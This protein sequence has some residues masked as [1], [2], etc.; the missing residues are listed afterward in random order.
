MVRFV[1][2]GAEKR[3]QFTRRRLFAGATGLALLG[4][5]AVGGRANA[6]ENT[7][8]NG[9]ISIEQRLDGRNIS[10]G[11][12]VGKMPPESN[13]PSLLRAI[14]PYNPYSQIN[15]FSIKV[16]GK[17]IY[18]PLSAVCDIYNL[19]SAELTSVGTGNYRL[20]IKAADGAE[21]YKVT[22]AFNSELINGRTVSPISTDFI[23]EKTSYKMQ[24]IP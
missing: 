8:K 22:L 21:S 11:I 16:D 7:P 23:L 3:S 5:Y 15:S 2:Q 1:I 20:T 19:K 18:V 10:V 17:S 13:I 6:H 24:E 14:T 9:K 12:V 4:I